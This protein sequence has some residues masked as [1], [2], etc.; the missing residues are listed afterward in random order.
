MQAQMSASVP[1]EADWL[2]QS[3]ASAL[4]EALKLLISELIGWGEPI[5]DPYL[6]LSS[7]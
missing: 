7:H 2:D 1:L 3:D 5:D 4:A 6:T